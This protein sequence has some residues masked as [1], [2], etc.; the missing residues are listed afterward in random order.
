MGNRRSIDLRIYRHGCGLL[1]F[2][3]ATTRLTGVNRPSIRHIAIVLDMDMDANHV[4]ASHALAHVIKALPAPVL[5]S[6]PRLIHTRAPAM[7]HRNRYTAI[8]P[9][10]DDTRRRALMICICNKLRQSAPKLHQIAQK[11]VRHPA[12]RRFHEKP[13]D[14]PD[15]PPALKI[16]LC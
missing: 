11:I 2:H 15:P 6:A 4:R 14:P 1:T 8:I 10:P 16:E 7:P 9:S 3:V 5:V 13:P 12:V